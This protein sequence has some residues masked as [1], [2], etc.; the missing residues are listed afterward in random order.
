[1]VAESPDVP[2]REELIA[3]NQAQTAQIAALMARVA[4]LER[5]LGLNSLD[6]SF[7]CNG[8]CEGRDFVGYGFCGCFPAQCLSRLVVHQC[9]DIVEPC[10]TGVAQIGALGQERAQEAVGV[11]VAA[12]LPGGVRIAE[13][14]VDL[15]AARQFRVAGYFEAA[16]IEPAPDLIRC[17]ACA[18][19]GG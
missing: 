11:F 1:M 6:S 9:G 8:C 10:L 17:Q 4:E 19:V 5:R 15:Q 7:K 13:P 16:V 2:S 18:R 3:L 14:D 12:T